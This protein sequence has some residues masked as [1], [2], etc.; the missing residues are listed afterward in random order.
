[1][2]ISIRKALPADVEIL[3]F[4]IRESVR[5]LARGIYDEGQIEL[6]ITSVFGVDHDL[7]DDGTYFVAEIDGELAGCGG[8]SR[9]KTLYGASTYAE[10]RDPEYL[11]P[12]SDAAKIR[13]FFVHPRAARKGVGTALL[14]VCEREARQNGFRVAEMMSTMPGVP[15][16]SARG[17]AGEDKIEVPVGNGV[18]ITCIR[19]SK[20]L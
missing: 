2:S 9:R 3:A 5:G 6:S 14:E 1:M 4:L 7:I 8:W 10:S 20:K 11:D 15:L 18:T 16:Y 13:A 17:Y 19:M 12:K